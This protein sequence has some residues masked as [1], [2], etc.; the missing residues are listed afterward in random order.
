M[1]DIRKLQAV[2]QSAYDQIE[3]LCRDHERADHDDKVCT[4]T[5]IAAIAMIA[6]ALGL[7]SDDTVYQ[8]EFLIALRKCEEQQ[9]AKK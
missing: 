4:S 2:C 9:R 1:V 3:T 6:N 5:R 8:M 7:P